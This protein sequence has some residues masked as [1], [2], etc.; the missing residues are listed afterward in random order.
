MRGFSAWQT[1]VAIF[2]TG[3]ASLVGVP[4]YILLARKFDTRGLMMFGLASFGVLD[5]EFQFHHP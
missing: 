4:V 1:G 5:V 2:S 3:A